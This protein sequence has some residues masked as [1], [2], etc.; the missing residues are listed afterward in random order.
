MQN[1]FN[2]KK[3]KLLLNSG[4]RKGASEDFDEL[5]KRATR[6]SKLIKEKKS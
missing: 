4:G 2:S 6:Y 5:L 1:K 3:I